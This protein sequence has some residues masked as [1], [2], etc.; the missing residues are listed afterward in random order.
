[1]PDKRRVLFPCMIC[2][3][4]CG[5][6]TI[7]CI[8]C[9]GW[10]HKICTT[11]SD[12]TF[13]EFNG[14]GVKFECPRCFE[15]HNN[16]SYDWQVGLNKLK[17]APAVETARRIISLQRHKENGWSKHPRSRGCHIGRNTEGVSP[18]HAD[19]YDAVS[20]LRRRHLLR[21]V[22]LTYYKIMTLFIRAANSA[23]IILQI[24]LFGI[25]IVQNQI[26]EVKRCDVF[27]FL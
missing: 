12:E 13:A 26:K 4:A 21:H 7:Q 24:N 19:C 27:M 10:L 17:A 20:S 9:T 6:G 2:D 8:S 14:S 25:I 15:R 3:K 11:M 23:I 1:M 18:H 22:C 16:G 5:V